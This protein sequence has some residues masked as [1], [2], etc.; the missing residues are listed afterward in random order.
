MTRTL[1][2]LPENDK[3][4]LENFSHSR[5]QSFAETIR[6]AIKKFRKSIQNKDQDEFLTNTAGLWKSHDCDSLK[7]VEDLRKEWD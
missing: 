5:K 4:W 6:Q 2:T 1:I 3:E 7:Y